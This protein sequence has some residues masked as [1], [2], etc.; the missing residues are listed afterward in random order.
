MKIG[1][2][3]YPGSGKSTVF[4]AL[5]GLDGRHGLRRGQGEPRRREGA[6]RARRR[7]RGA[8][9]AQEDHLRRDH[10]Q[11]S[12]RRARRGARPH[13]AQSRCATSTRCARCCA[14]SPTPR[15]SPATRSASCAA[16]RPRRCS[17]TSSSSSSAWRKLTKDRSNPRE[18]ALLERVQQAL[19]SEQAV[20]TLGLTEE[21]S[22]SLAGYALLTAKPLLLVLNVA[23]GD[24][25]APAPEA[26]ARAA[27]RARARPGRA[28]GAGRDGH[29]AAR[30]GRAGR[31]PRVAR[32][33]GAG[34]APLHPR[35]VRADRSDQHAHRRPRRVPRL[36]RAARHARA[37]RGRQDPQ[38]H[39][40]RL[41]PRRGDPLRGPARARQRGEVQATPARC[42]IEGK[43]Y[44]VQDGDV[45]HFRFNV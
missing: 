39:R 30:A 15:A 6:R 17:P 41:H 21:E 32:A 24:V 12:R 29:R 1:L 10:L 43:D 19:E 34:R 4:G 16:S 13:G 8:L 36:A 33:R 45:V 20:R 42:A 38:R 7:A 18:L 11:R 14:R 9:P 27:E 3:G 44:V 23:E 2:V 25:A 35:R 22:K 37:A 5:T 31:V 40:A 28:L 26:L